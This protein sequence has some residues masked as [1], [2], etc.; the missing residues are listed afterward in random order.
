MKICPLP[1][2]NPTEPDPWV[3][4]CLQGISGKFGLHT[5]C[6]VDLAAGSLRHSRMLAGQFGFR[7]VIAIDTNPIVSGPLEPAIEVRQIDACEFRAAANSLDVVVWWNSAYLF[8]P[9][10][11][12]DLLGRIRF[13]LKKGGI[14]L[15]N[16]LMLP[17]HVDTKFLTS[18][19][20][21]KVE[22]AL[23]GFA[24]SATQ[25][26]MNENNHDQKIPGL[27]ILRVLACKQ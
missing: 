14:F 12:R 23:R 10:R 1:E 6:A 7:K 22:S 11:I 16:F 24:V 15:G 25:A 18:F 5:D 26:P 13:S 17:K 27:K 20:K 3:L 4:E 19:P 8:E 2:R 9:G 21:E